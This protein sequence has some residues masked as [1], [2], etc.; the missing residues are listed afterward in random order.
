ML[1]ILTGAFIDPDIQDYLAGTTFSSFSFDF[2]PVVK[3]PY[4]NYPARILHFNQDIYEL[5]MLG[6]TS[7]SALINNY[8]LL[9]T[10]ILLIVL[11]LL[12]L[13]VPR[14]R[15]K[16]EE[17]KKYKCIR[18]TR[19]NIK[20]MLRFTL[21]IRFIIEGYQFIVLSSVSEIHGFFVFAKGNLKS[22]ITSGVLQ[23]FCIIFFV[24]SICL[25][26]KKRSIS[27]TKAKYLEFF[28]G[29]KYKKKAKY[30]TG[31]NLLRRLIYIPTLI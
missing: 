18:L 8:S 10:L 17:T 31:I 1:L 15:K 26:Y 30:Y 24:L 27:G 16:E 6:M 4:Y 3:I 22:T 25:I 23:L 14:C 13:C 9:S 5:N 11:N 29:L 19:R 7:G 28:A 2:I 20:R 21:L 12:F